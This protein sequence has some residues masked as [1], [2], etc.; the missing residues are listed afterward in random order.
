M[1]ASL[2]QALHPTA[3]AELSEAGGEGRVATPVGGR[4]FHA[5]D[6]MDSHEARTVLGEA[7]CRYRAMTY[8]K[9]QRLLKEE[10]CFRTRGASGVPYQIAVEAV[11]DNKPGETCASWC[12]LTT[13]AFEPSFH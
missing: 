12:T 3:A 9:L 13:A 8:E 4:R 11:W 6:V 10:D 7:I 2:I 5:S 1:G